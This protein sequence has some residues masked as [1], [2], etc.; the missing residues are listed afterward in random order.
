[1]QLM[2]TACVLRAC[3]AQA[4]LMCRVCVPHVCV[5][6][7]STSPHPS[8]LHCVLYCV[9]HCVLYCV[10]LCTVSSSSHPGIMHGV[11]VCVFVYCTGLPFPT[12]SYCS[13]CVFVC[14]CE[15]VLYW[16]SSSHPGI[17]HCVYCTVLHCL[18]CSGSPLPTQAYLLL[19]AQ[20]SEALKKVGCAQAA[21]AC[22][23]QHT[24]SPH[25]HVVCS[26]K[27]VHTCTLFAAHRQYTRARC[28]QHKGST[29]V[30]VVCSTQSA[31]KRCTHMQYTH[32]VHIAVH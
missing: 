25:V 11:C 23:S 30:H 3:T 12:L 1:M 14:V 10:L 18:Y 16:S 9:L 4:P 17:L 31:H 8:I 15:C 26:T 29:H 28:L 32:A 2:Y 13:V 6:L 27:A 20:L 5:V 24:G 19:Q 22:C 7:P 21:R